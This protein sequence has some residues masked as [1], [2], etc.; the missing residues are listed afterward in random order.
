M[1]GV[2]LGQLEA[3]VLSLY[4]VVVPDGRMLCSKG[5]KSY[6]MLLPN[7]HGQNKLKPNWILQIV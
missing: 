6:R 1:S 4:K 5:E 7:I 3:F 2:S